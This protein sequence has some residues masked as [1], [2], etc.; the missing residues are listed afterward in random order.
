[1]PLLTPLP[2]PH[3]TRIAARR[4]IEW[5]FFA[6]GA[7][8]AVF[9]F[10]A[11]ANGTV[12]RRS[13]IGVLQNPPFFAHLAATVVSIPM[14]V[15]LVNRVGSHLRATPRRSRV[16]LA[17]LEKSRLKRALY[18][19]VS[20]VGLLSLAA[21]VVMAATFQ[22]DVYDAATLHPT[23]F[24][25]Y[26]VIRAYQYLICYPLLVASPIVLT[27][28]FFRTLQ[29]CGLS[30]LPFAKDGAGGLRKYLRTV[31]RP[32][33]AIQVMATLIA[34]ANYLGWGG[35]KPV[36]V[37]LAL[38][39]LLAITVIGVMLHALFWLFA[40]DLQRREISQIRDRQGRLYSQIRSEGRKRLVD[41]KALI[42]EIEAGDRLV[43][44]IRKRRHLG[45][46]KYPANV[47]LA[48]LPI[49]IKAVP[50][51]NML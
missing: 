34:G 42:E 22:V 5:H 2:L 43:E 3:T 40:R 8:Y 31:D 51:L 48:L 33:Y 25:A 1:L 26:T 20:L 13:G 44:I 37:A 27:A 35:M 49:A 47:I 32:V 24:A 18:G 29:K 11:L 7:L 19:L 28:L 21:S 4:A 12:W 23:T 41:H 14:V 45:W 10:L 30:Y 38:G 15:L 39:A 36:P 9:L 17:L 46:L 6:T 16:F 50:G